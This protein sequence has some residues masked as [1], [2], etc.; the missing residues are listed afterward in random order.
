MSSICS[1]KRSFSDDLHL[2]NL[3]KSSELKIRLQ[4]ILS[5]MGAFKIFHGRYNSKFVTILDYREEGD[6]AHE[7]NRITAEV[8]L[9]E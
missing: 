4:F 5:I 1:I 2:L 8:L 7:T 3:N 9:E 6:K